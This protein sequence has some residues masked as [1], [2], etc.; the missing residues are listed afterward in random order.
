MIDTKRLDEMFFLFGLI[1][2]IDKDN[3][4]TIALET[5]LGAKLEKIVPLVLHGIG[6]SMKNNLPL[7]EGFLDFISEAILY[8][9]GDTDDL[10]Q[11]QYDPEKVKKILMNR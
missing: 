8:I 9:K 2:P 11:T 10:P 3:P 6:D 5:I 1:L 7:A 4:N